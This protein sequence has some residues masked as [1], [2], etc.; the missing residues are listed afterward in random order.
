[1]REVEGK[2]WGQPYYRST[3]HPLASQASEY[4]I[5]FDFENLVNEVT[6]FTDDVEDNQISIPMNFGVKRYNQINNNFLIAVSVMIVNYFKNLANQVIALIDSTLMDNYL[7]SRATTFMTSVVGA[8]WCHRF[9]DDR[10][11]G[12]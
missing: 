5:A 11:V 10:S 3:G 12:L 6:Q 9:S 7:M 8:L 4:S 1:M 2:L